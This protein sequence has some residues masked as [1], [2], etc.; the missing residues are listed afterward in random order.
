MSETD[1]KNNDLM[2]KLKDVV[3]NVEEEIFHDSK[4]R[5]KPASDD[6]TAAGGPYPDG[7]GTGGGD[8]GH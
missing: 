7:I 6:R 5:A 3:A 4:D 1:N 2:T 8:G